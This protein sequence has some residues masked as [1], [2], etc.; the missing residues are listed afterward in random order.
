MTR[1]FKVF[2]VVVVDQHDI[3]IIQERRSLDNRLNTSMAFVNSRSES[4]AFQNTD[5]NQE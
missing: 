4:K 2:A 1:V 5:P 3:F